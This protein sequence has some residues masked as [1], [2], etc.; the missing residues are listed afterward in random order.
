MVIDVN[1]ETLELFLVRNKE[2]KWFR[3]KGLDGTGKSWVDN[4]K[5]ARMYVNIGPAKGIVT[6]FANRY[7]Q[8]GVPDIVKLQVRHGE[9]LKQEDRV[10]ETH[11]KQS[12]GEANRITKEAKKDIKTF[13][14]QIDESLT[15]VKIK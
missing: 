8:F 11:I 12:I 1:I 5:N 3:A 15:K 4:I 14:K 7:P 10:K 9:I 13:E 2:G 6:W